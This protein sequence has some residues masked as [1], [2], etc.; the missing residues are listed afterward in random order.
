V[1][2]TDDRAELLR[3]QAMQA[4]LSA[5]GAA[6]VAVYGNEPAVRGVVLESRGELTSTTYWRIGD[7]RWQYEVTVRVDVDRRKVDL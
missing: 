2:A 4:C 6:T 3:T 7:D 1:T 5:M